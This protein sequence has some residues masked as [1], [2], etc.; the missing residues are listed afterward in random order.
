[1]VPLEYQL[2]FGASDLSLLLT[3]NYKRCMARTYITL[4]CPDGS[5]G[6]CLPRSHGPPTTGLKREQQ[7]QHNQQTEQ[8]TTDEQRRGGL[9]IC[10]TSNQDTDDT[11]HPV[12]DHA[13][14]ITRSS[15]GC[16]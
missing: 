7:T 5:A 16:R 6:P 15:M 2:V 9:D 1:M 10:V 8:R 14:R 3:S 11:T 4:R 12:Q 13:N